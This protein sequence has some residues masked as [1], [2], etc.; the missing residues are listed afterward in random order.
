MRDSS[1]KVGLFD[2]DPWSNVTPFHTQAARGIGDVDIYGPFEAPG[3]SFPRG[4]IPSKGN[5]VI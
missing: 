3:P 5:P 4:Y 2:G 1:L